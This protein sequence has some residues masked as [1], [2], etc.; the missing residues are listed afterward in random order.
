MSD[1]DGGGGLL[2]LVGFVV[3]LGGVN[4][5]SYLFGWGFWVY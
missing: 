4:L 5:A 1:G 2:G 3:L